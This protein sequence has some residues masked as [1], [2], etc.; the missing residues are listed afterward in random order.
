MKK[1]L[2]ITAYDE[3]EWPMDT[4]YYATQN[5]DASDVLVV[6]AE[7]LSWFLNT[8]LIKSLDKQNESEIHLGEDDWIPAVETRKVCIKIIENWLCMS[9]GAKH[10]L[11]IDKLLELFKQSI[12]D[13]QIA[14]CFIYQ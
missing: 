5:P 10:P 11:V 14:V 8:T 2:Y 4:M 3:S 9:E 7:E 1:K 13:E 12:N 6:E